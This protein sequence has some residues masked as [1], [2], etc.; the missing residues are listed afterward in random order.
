MG[1]WCDRPRRCALF[2]MNDSDF[3]GSPGKSQ[4]N[5]TR[6][7][8]HEILGEIKPKPQSKIILIGSAHI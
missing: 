2:L 6:K 4:T 5:E 1:S 7:C 3:I 8:N